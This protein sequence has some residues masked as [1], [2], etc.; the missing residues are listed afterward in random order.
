M[1]GGGRCR[2]QGARGRRHRRQQPT[3][4]TTLELARIWYPAHHS[5]PLGSEDDVRVHGCALWKPVFFDPTAAGL[6]V[7]CRATTLDAGA[8]AGPCRAGQSQQVP[9]EVVLKSG[10][11]LGVTAGELI[12]GRDPAPV[13]KDQEMVKRWG[14]VDEFPTDDQERPVLVLGSLIRE[15]RMRLGCRKTP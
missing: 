9:A 1:S 13:L 11:A 14:A 8:T 10:E 5:L 12:G 7:A 2:S 15:A 3:A 6:T 4:S